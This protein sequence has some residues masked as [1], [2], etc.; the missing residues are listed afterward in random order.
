MFEALIIVLSRLLLVFIGF[1]L[2]R[3]FVGRGVFEQHVIG[4][5]GKILPGAPRTQQGYIFLKGSRDKNVLSK[6]DGVS[7]APWGW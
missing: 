4:R 3:M 7:K 5:S 2:Y 1:K 6:V